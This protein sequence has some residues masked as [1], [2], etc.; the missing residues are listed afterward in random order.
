MTDVELFS[1]PG[2]DP[3][4]FLSEDNTTEPRQEVPGETSNIAEGMGEEKLQD[5]ADR[6]IREYKQD[7][8]DMSG[9]QDMHAEWLRLY[10]Q[11]DKP[12]EPPFDYASEESLPILAEA[13]TQFSARAYKAFFPNNNIIKAVPIGNATREDWERGLRLS[14][15][16]SWQLLA[17]DRT[18]KRNKRRLL[19]STAVHGSHF[20]KTFYDPVE[21]RNRVV[22]VR[23]ADLVVPY[24]TG[25]RD[26]EDVERKTHVIYMS[27]DRSNLLHRKGFFL[28]PLEIEQGGDDRPTTTVAKDIEGIEPTGQDDD[29]TQREG[30]VLEQHRLLDL[31]E[32]GIF[33]PYIVWVDKEAEKVLRI[34]PRFEGDEENS[35]TIEH[36]THYPFIENPD[37]FYGL[38]MGHLVG[39]LNKA[40]NKILRQISDASMLANVGNHSGFID[41]SIAPAGGDL[42]MDLGKFKKVN[43]AGDLQKGVFQFKFPGPPTVMSQVIELLMGRA[44]RL[45]S[46]TEMI[47]GQPE[48]VMQPTVVLALIEQAMEQYSSVYEGLF[49][50]WSDELQKIYR[51]NALYMDEQEY[52][53]ALDAKPEEQEQ[54][55]QVAQADYAPDMQVL[56][57]ADPK[58]ATDQQR[59]SRAE[60]E[61]Q[62]VNNYYLQ[63][64]Q[65]HGPNP[66]YREPM[67]NAI[68]RY[69]E[70]MQTNDLEEI[71]IPPPPPPEPRRVD[72]ARLENAAYLMPQGEPPPE[73][74]VDQD[75]VEHVRVH[76]ELLDDQRFGQ[77]IT[78]E[79]KEALERHIQEHVS[80]QYA[81]ESGAIDDTGRASQ[82]VG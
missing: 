21:S 46:V 51:L 71:L 70:A 65:I 41:Q 20:T 6:V 40:I 15:H 36:F 42:H 34:S 81:I 74:F 63:E 37:G 44:D 32:T 22:N 61:Y 69:M 58:M 53:T 4:D 39:Q 47:S 38:G 82:M 7:V 57:V 75:H 66:A 30:V 5:I 72:D 28:Q 26:I 79:G 56:P 24:G 60:I 16:L 23:A 17:K 62:T 11:T 50:A 43:A 54:A 27:L 77:Q 10:A 52:F 12:I 3:Q 33:K 64:I 19:L 76:K 55:I 31:D 18:Y 68:R 80:M 9:W 73:V 29:D 59:L 13:C 2:L 78:P 8:Q 25:P 67:F 45:A 49:D 48:R 35:I 14:K 1:E